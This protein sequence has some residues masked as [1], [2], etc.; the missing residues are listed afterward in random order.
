MKYKIDK[1]IKTF[2]VRSRKLST[3]QIN[4]INL[5]WPLIG[6][7]LDKKNFLMNKNDFL[8]SYSPAIL[9]I[10]FGFGESLIY[11]CQKYTNINFVGIE[12]YIPGISYCLKKIHELNLKNIRIIYANALYFFIY[13]AQNIKFYKINIFFPD[14]WPKRKHHKRRIIQKELIKSIIKNLLVNGTLHIITDS[15]SYYE[16]ILRILRKFD[17]LQNISKIFQNSLCKETITHSR[18][19]KKALIKKNKIYNI[20]YKKIF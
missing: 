4:N 18:F 3:T 16:S 20:L 17:R 9:E 19:E 14:P 11:L 15:F 1:T 8:N 5:Y 2:N 6:I 13:Y 7:N 12:V 10:G